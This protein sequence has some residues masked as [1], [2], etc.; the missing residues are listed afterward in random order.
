M[1]TFRLISLSILLLFGCYDAEVPLGRVEDSIIDERLAGRWA[2]DA[3]LIEDELVSIRIVPFNEH[4]Y[5]L[6]YWTQSNPET[7]PK[8]VRLRGF[9]TNVGEAQFGNLQLI[10]DED[11]DYL[12]V[13]YEITDDGLLGIRFVDKDMSGIETSEALYHFVSDMFESG[14]LEDEEMAYFRREE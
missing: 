3:G 11:D 10:Q 1:K 5:Y 14:E 13:Q 2:P 8:I 6:E 7:Y 4:E 9:A 12:I